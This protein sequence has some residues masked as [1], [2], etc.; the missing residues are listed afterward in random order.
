MYVYI[1]IYIVSVSINIYDDICMYVCLST[2]V[3]LSDMCLDLRMYVCM[4]ACMSTKFYTYMTLYFHHAWMMLRFYMFF[5]IELPW[6]LAR[7]LEGAA[8]WNPT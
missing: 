3:C 8:L 4:Y 1:Y 2:Y 6:L 5:G 7:F